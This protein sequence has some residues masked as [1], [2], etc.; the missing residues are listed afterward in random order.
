MP[1]VTT[2]EGVEIFCWGWVSGRPVMFHTAGR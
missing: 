2:G 1:L